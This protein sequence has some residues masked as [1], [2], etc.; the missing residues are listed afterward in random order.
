MPPDQPQQPDRP[1]DPATDEAVARL[2][3]EA[4]ADEPV[5]DA[6]AS[7]LDAALADLVAERAA[8]P[9]DPSTRVASPPPPHALPPPVSLAA[10]RHRRR[11]GLLL[12]A[13]AVVAVGAVGVVLPQLDLSGNED[14]TGGSAEQLDEAPE[15]APSPGD[16]AG[17][18]SE[19]Q[20]EGQSEDQPGRGDDSGGDGAEPPAAPALPPTSAG[21]LVDGSATPLRAGSLD[22]DAA[23][24]VAGVRASPDVVRDARA[25]QCG[26]VTLRDEVGVVTTYEGELVVLV[27]PT[28][29]SG[30]DL[31]VVSCAS[32]EEIA[33]A[34][35]R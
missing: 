19:D 17:A 10:R 31:P 4:R 7:R 21:T 11:T 24:A 34:S 23:A 30:G 14:S 29:G 6:V 26:A 18:Q 8:A 15:S 12:A 20:S 28:S 16:G 22:A 13:A 5:P 33:S 9:P 27:V 3:R 25:E 32:G 2:L 1:L 35:V